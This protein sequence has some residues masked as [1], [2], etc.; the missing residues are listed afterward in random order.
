MGRE[1]DIAPYPDCS[2]FSRV[3][4]GM[5]EEI[6]A[7]LSSLRPLPEKKFF[8]FG[9]GRTGSTLL[10][11]SLDTHSRIHCDDEILGH[12]RAFPVWF[13]EN[14]ARESAAECFGFHVKCYQLWKWQRVR[15]LESIIRRLH[16]RQWKIIYL[17]RENLFEH[18][19]SSFVASVSKR[20][21][22]KRS[23]AATAVQPVYIAPKELKELMYERAVYQQHERAAL[24]TI[25]HLP[26]S[27]EDDLLEDA[28]KIKTFERIQDY[29]G[30]P[31]ERLEIKL[32]KIVD[33]PFSEVVVNFDE[34]TKELANSEYRS[35]CP[36]RIEAAR[37]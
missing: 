1:P 23:E 10:T 34:I 3:Q 6:R 14:R 36:T 27:Y 21:H 22:M 5:K 8:I 17:R 33:R 35:F 13:V 18:T 19:V 30:V 31:Y 32:R 11:S 9:Q 7:A 16:R 4:A 25:P 12:P 15:T 29:I 24:Q 20:W 37:H 2:V 26:L 28:A